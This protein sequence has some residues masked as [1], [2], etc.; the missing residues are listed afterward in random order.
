MNKSQE[1]S[2]SIYGAIIAII[3]FILYFGLTMLATNQL[4]SL[5]SG[6]SKEYQEEAKSELVS[7][8]AKLSMQT[9]E[10]VNDLYNWE[11]IQQ[12][13]N[14]PTYYTY[15][16]SSRV[17]SANFI[18]SYFIK[19]SLYDK[20]A[21]SLMGMDG[22]KN[23]R[24]FGPEIDKSIVHL[25]EGKAIIERC[26]VLS[27]IYGKK[28][29]LGYFCVELDLFKGLTAVQA[30][31]NL[32]IESV[33]ITWDSNNRFVLDNLLEYVTYAAQGVKTISKMHSLTVDTIVKYMV[34]SAVAILVFVYILIVPLGK[35]LRGLSS[36][37]N[38]LQVSGSEKSYLP[39]GGIFKIT[40]LNTVYKSL[41]NYQERLEEATQ[42]LKNSEEYFRSLIENSSDVILSL[43]NKGMIIYA[44]PSVED[45]LGYKKS[46][47]IGDHVFEYI[48]GNDIEPFRLSTGEKNNVINAFSQVDF[49]FKH[50]N[51]EWLTL[52]LAGKAYSDADNSC[53]VICRDITERKKV[54]EAISLAH[55]QALEASRAKSNFLANTSHELRTPL[56]AILGYAEIIA[57]D[58]KNNDYTNAEDDVG[59]V[60]TAARS[61]L[62]LIDEVLDLS[63]I[64]SGKMELEV[65]EISVQELVTE[66][67]RTITP[68]IS[69]NSNVLE[70]N[71]SETVS[72]M[73]TDRNK[74]RQIIFN[75]L[76]NSAK[77][78]QNGEVTLDVMVKKV[79]ER[80]CI[81][82]TVTDTG[83]GMTKEQAEKVFE[84]FVQAD[85]STTRKFGGTGLG[86]TICR[87]FAHL[88][89]GE[90][91]VH[92]EEGIGSAFTLTLPVKIRNPEQRVF[93]RKAV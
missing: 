72:T 48:H 58:M 45:V 75:L 4:D 15:W 33:N 53:T 5:K 43:D 78:T 82:F 1:I 54:Q 44:S 12:Q 14:D 35:P 26:A 77:F 17:S 73:Y 55:D 10:L 80:D 2:I 57:E 52:E 60:H 69:R 31:D 93:T 36:H 86:L 34:V 85:T 49:R 27:E 7:A 56:N 59:K 23:I 38:A 47:I 70:V 64:E 90:I 84:P 28:N 42:E 63:K 20:N 81:E 29:I 61:L 88:M 19:L 22:E 13:I 79:G 89:H 67:E 11:E 76:N 51:G 21:I 83:V 87:S 65:H 30:F 46:K 92:S 74:L 24:E 6:F 39:D 71:I 37:I 32:D 68:L 41:N 8:V 62:H 9:N 25:S 3:G 40:E 91:T 18:P 50:N 66:I 16:Q